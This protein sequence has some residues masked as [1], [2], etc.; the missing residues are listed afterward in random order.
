[1]NAKNTALKLNE[2]YN[3]Q[4]AS[5]MVIAAAQNRRGGSVQGMASAAESEY[6][7]DLAYAAFEGDLNYLNRMSEADSA[8]RAADAAGIG[9]RTSLGMGLL[10]AGIAGYQAQAM[11]NQIGGKSGG[12]TTTKNS[13]TEAPGR[14]YGF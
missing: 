6:E 1:M 13:G 5:N 4:M 7:W 3:K 9:A 12:K 8:G 10:N 14:Q 11:E 2:D